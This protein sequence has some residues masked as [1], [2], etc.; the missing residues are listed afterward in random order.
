[1]FHELFDF[2]LQAWSNALA[3]TGLLAVV[4]L[5]CQHGIDVTTE[6]DT[7]H[8]MIRQ[9]RFRGRLP[10]AFLGLVILCFAIPCARKFKAA[11]NYSKYRSQTS[12]RSI[13]WTPGRKDYERRI[14]IMRSLEKTIPC[15]RVKSNLA[16][17]CANY[18][19]LGGADAEKYWRMACDYAAVSMR[20]APLDGYFAL[21][22]AEIFSR[23]NARGM[24]R[25]PDWSQLRLFLWACQCL[26][27]KINCVDRTA[28]EACKYY[29]KALA[30]FQDEVPESRQRALDLLAK[31]IAIN[32]SKA[33]AYIAVLAEIADNEQMLIDLA[34]DNV[35]VKMALARYFASVRNYGASLKI[36]DGIVSSES[37]YASLDY[38][39]RFAL[40]DSSCGIARLQGDEQRF[41]RD[42]GTLWTL[43]QEKKSQLVNEILN[44]REKQGYKSTLASLENL[45][46]MNPSMPEFVVTLAQQYRFL[47]I[48]ADCVHLLLQLTYNEE[49][50]DLKL[51][52]MAREM[53]GKADSTN[54][55]DSLFVRA[56]F[57]DAAIDVMLAENNS[58]SDV[59]T[60]IGK[61][62]KLEDQQQS[63]SW[64][65]AH[66][67]PFF[68]ARGY[69]CLKQ[70]DEAIEAYMRA[71][72]ISPNNLF[73][74]KRL[75]RLT[76]EGLSAAQL[77][78]LDFCGKCSMSRSAVSPDLTHLGFVSDKEC[79]EAL[80]SKLKWRVMMLCTSDIKTEYHFEMSFK[81]RKG[82]CFAETFDWSGTSTPMVSWRVG[83][84]Y[85]SNFEWQPHLKTLRK[86]LRTMESGD[87]LVSMSVK[88]L[89]QKLRPMPSIVGH[90]WKVK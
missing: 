86:S 23:A 8:E 51:L 75:K 60:A 90:A 7:T 54:G 38:D 67:I 12:S 35:D 3:V 10:L 73:V 37:L 83:E 57:L 77:E 55:M 65:Q 53:L 20:M 29:I 19:K 28:R 34:K 62:K 43:C 61:L 82:F 11:I 66:L 4:S 40:F 50:P 69:E 89:K 2:N 21:A 56:S 18:A 9:N 87:V 47:G 58:G 52:L 41:A 48:T 32:P 45:V 78:L 30:I 68:I 49:A 14:G 39:R 72:A 25:D 70:Q 63:K 6:K 33:N 76:T 17:L 31:C 81:D 79:I 42:Y 15:H 1:M 85:S 74:L 24:R 71:I 13:F 26:P 64:M 59:R 88:I 5:T 27:N 84:V 22:C 16:V 46:Y 44:A 36:I 80:H